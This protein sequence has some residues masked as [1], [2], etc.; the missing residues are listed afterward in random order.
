VGNRRD[1]ERLQARVE[2]LERSEQLLR[3]LERASAAMVGALQP[4]HV[5]EA[6]GDTLVDLGLQTVVLRKTADHRLRVAKLS[7]S[8][9]V[10]SSI[11]KR[12]GITER[13]FSIDYRRVDFYRNIVEQRRSIHVGDTFEIAASVLPGLAAPLVR[14][15]L[16][17][18]GMSQMIGAPLIVG[19]DVWGVFVISSVRL[20]PADVSAVR[21]FAHQVGWALHKTRLLSS[22]NE[23]IQSMESTQAQL[24]QAQKMEALGR[25]TGGIAHDLNNLLTGILMSAE[26]VRLD[27]P[28]DQAVRTELSNIVHTSQRAADLVKQLLAFSRR[29]ALRKVLVDLSNELQDLRPLLHR[30][31]GEDIRLRLDLGCEEPCVTRIDVPQLEQVILNL[32]VNARDAMPNGGDL[33]LRVR[34]RTPDTTPEGVEPCPMLCLSVED[35]GEGIPNH[36]KARLFDP[37]FTTKP[38]DKGTGL[39]LSVAYGI[40]RQH[41]GWLAVDSE[42]GVGS[43]F[44][45]W[46]PAAEVGPQEVIPKQRTPSDEFQVP[47]GLGSIL[48]VED[49]AT[50]RGVVQRCLERFETNLHV[51]TT[52]EEARRQFQTKSPDLIICDVVLPDGN[53]LDLCEELHERHPGLSV[54]LVSG[55]TDRRVDL[56]AIDE[57]GWV[58]LPKPFSAGDLLRAIETTKH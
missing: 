1:I 30:V 48:L 7:L 33:V 37:F 29:Q 23:T 9:P 28:E 44:H 45:V 22:L 31:I 38:R 21:L 54:V 26:L 41:G 50:L 8:S 13:Q 18:L 57:K 58:F 46:L 11:E 47:D 14:F 53:G 15:V 39:G 52:V 17:R 16:D 12:V 20:T 34:K 56:R 42:V 24:I 6:I 51:A 10:V 5:I 19:N 25:L 3:A 4:D 32:V 35:T 43:R 49:E 36:I 27:S 55:Y 2:E 40:V